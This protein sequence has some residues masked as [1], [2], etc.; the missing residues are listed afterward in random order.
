MKI[1]VVGSGGREH[2]LIWKLRQSPRVDEICCAPGN[3]GIGEIAKLVPIGPEEIK[4]LANF[5]EEEKIDLTV[6]GP[7]LPLTLGISDLFQKQG[8]KVFGPNCEAARLEGS[9]VFAKELLEESH[10]PTAS[11]ATFA[12]A[13]TAKKYWAEKKP[14]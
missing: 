2:A 1:L 5:A 8:L 12:D 14:P 11:F 9:K 10:I 3:G 6:V 13:A 4:K 7:E